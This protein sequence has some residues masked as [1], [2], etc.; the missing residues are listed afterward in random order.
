YIAVADQQPQRVR[1]HRDRLLWEAD[2]GAQQ[3]QL[4]L[5]VMSRAQVA[6]E[7]LRLQHPPRPSPITVVTGADS[8]EMVFGGAH[9]G[10]VLAEESI[11]FLL[12]VRIHAQ[13]GSR[14]AV[15]SDDQVTDLQLADRAESVR[16]Q[17]PGADWHRSTPHVR[18]GGDLDRARGHELGDRVG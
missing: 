13:H 5:A 8:P 4:P 9:R 16:G 17:H 10:T 6:D 3:R 12:T 1:I 2:R 11:N 14:L 15:R 18:E 7:L